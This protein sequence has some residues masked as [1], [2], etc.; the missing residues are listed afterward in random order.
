[1]RIEVLRMLSEEQR[2]WLY[3]AVAKLVLIDERLDNRAKR[4]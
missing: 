4:G 1:M 2:G 3:R